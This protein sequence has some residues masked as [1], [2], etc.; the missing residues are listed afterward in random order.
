MYESTPLI[1]TLNPETIQYLNLHN[2]GIEC[3]RDINNGADVYVAYK[4]KDHEITQLFTFTFTDEMRIRCAHPSIDE[5]FQL[6]Y[7]DLII[8][9]S[10]L[11]NN[12]Y[13]R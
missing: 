9:D 11:K 7:R 13:W 12:S 2:I 5:I 8:T 10:F 3:K 1:K 6:Y 4:S